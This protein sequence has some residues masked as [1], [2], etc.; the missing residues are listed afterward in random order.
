LLTALLVGYAFPR[1]ILRV[2]L[3]RESGG[4]FSL[5]RACLRYIA[6]PAIVLIML[7]A[8]L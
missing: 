1:E 7:A 3:Y 6:P 5:W 2:E 4:F 8:L